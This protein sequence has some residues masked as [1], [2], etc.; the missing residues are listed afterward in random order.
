MG[1]SRNFPRVGL[2]DT[3]YV[4]FWLAVLAE[5]LASFFFMFA[6]SGSALR[7]EGA[8]TIFQQAL[9]A[10]L[11]T[12]SMIQAFR[13]VSLPLVHA[14]PVVSLAAFITG[15]A[16]L[17]R[18]A[19][20]LIAQ[21]F[22]AITGT[23]VVMAI[24]PQHARGKLGVTMPGKEV[25]GFQAFGVELVLTSLLVLTMLASID[26]NKQAAR[27]DYGTAA[28]MGVVVTGC[29]LIALPLTGC[30]LNPAR[31]LA[32][33]VFTSTWEHHWLRT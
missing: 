13:S 15:D 22:G 14:N 3:Y 12:A 19:C 7:W 24:S 9:A 31:S 30:G 16:G 28:A 6:V 29:Y 10:G 8:P 23:G 27:R 33:A 2:S 32:P 21:F 26:A 18:M 4:D 20:S 11:V 1:C 25:S 17:I 5:Y